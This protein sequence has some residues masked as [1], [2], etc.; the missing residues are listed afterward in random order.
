ME[1]LRCPNCKEP[2]KKQERSLVCPN[3]HRFDLARQGYVNLALRAK[4]A[5]DN[6]EMVKAR[7]AFLDKGYYD[8]LRDHV[9][10]ELKRT[11]GKSYADIACGEGHYTQAFAAPFEAAF[12]FDLAKEAIAYAAGQD[13]HTQY[14]VA[15]IFNLPLKDASLDAATLLF[16]PVP[17]DELKRVIRKGGTLITVSPGPRHLWQLKEFLYAT[18]YE[19]PYPQPQL[20]GFELVK[21]ELISEEKDIADVWELFEMTP[22]RYK[23]SAEGIEKAKTAGPMKMSVSFLVRTW[24]RI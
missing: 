16:A 15:S 22:Y 1:Y 14:A 21:E 17:E 23:T 3:G 11:A 12:G 4:P 6:R 7:T 5:G 19:N 20:P 9:A 8:F 24:R 13:K 10:E 2:L 18:P